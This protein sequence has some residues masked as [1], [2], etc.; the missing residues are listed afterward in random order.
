[1]IDLS[2]VVDDLAP[3]ESYKLKRFSADEYVNGVLVSDAAPL[4]VWI[5]AIVAPLTGKDLERLPEA[6]RVRGGIT[7]LSSVQLRTQ[8]DVSAPDMLEVD[9]ELYEVTHLEAWGNLGN[10]YRATALKMGH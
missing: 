5:R 2:S 4:D 9:G 1:M 3:A 10:Y 6:T 7:I 8:T